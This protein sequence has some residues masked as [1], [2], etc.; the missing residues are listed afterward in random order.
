MNEL[1]AK[2]F[3]GLE[4]RKAIL[5]QDLVD[6]EVLIKNYT[7]L[8]DEHHDL[9]K[10]SMMLTKVSDRLQGKLDKTN[11][12]LNSL[13]QKLKFTIEQLNKMQISK[14][15]NTIILIVFLMCYI[16]IEGVVEPIIENWASNDE[17][18]SIVN[19][20]TESLYNNWFGISA[21][22]FYLSMAV[23][24]IL[25]FFFK[26]IESFAERRIHEQKKQEIMQSNEV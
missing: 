5:S 6:K 8:I 20:A 4:Q 1:F 19:L 9:I 2:E 7:E 17:E 24:I 11:D 18:I 21:K 22:A 25:A 26:P 23:K 15:A 12:K 3:E 14:K 16:F 10:Q 13:N